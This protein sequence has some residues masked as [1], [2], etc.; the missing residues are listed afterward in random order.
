VADPDSS[1]GDPETDSD[2]N[3]GDYEDPRDLGGCLLF[4]FRFTG[5]FTSLWIIMILAIIAV[6]FLSLLFW[7]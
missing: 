7:R 1:P 4:F 3:L 5:C 2:A 6:A